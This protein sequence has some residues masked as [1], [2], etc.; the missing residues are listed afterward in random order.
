MNDTLIICTR[1][2]PEDLERTLSSIVVQSQQPKT[3]LIV[4]SSTSSTTFDVYLKFKDCIQ[5]LD[6]IRSDERGLTIARNIGLKS[7][8]Q[9]CEVVHFIDDD[10]ELDKSYICE[11][12]LAF[13]E[14]DSLVGVGG[15]VMGSSYNGVKWPAAFLGMDS[16]KL[17]RVLWT[18]VNIGS[19]DCQDQIKMEWLPGCS[20]S[21]RVSRIEGLSFDTKRALQPLGEDVDFGLRAS[22]RGTLLHI[23]SAK[24]FHHLSP[25]NRDSHLELVK[26]DVVHRWTLAADGL[27]RVRRGGVLLSTV[28]LAAAF[29]TIG[30]LSLDARR[31]SLAKALLSGLLSALLFDGLRA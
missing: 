23:P 24:L 10:V 21:F 18:G 27:G 29:S 25:E 4:D 13:H 2:R 15:Q 31:L 7:I 9:D 26:Q 17:G 12:L 28:L 1:N 20:M 22:S 5:N 6:I 19:Y 11:I 14:D 30:L 8:S 3:T 16:R